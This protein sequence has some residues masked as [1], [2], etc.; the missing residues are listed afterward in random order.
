MGTENAIQVNPMKRTDAPRCAQ[1]EAPQHLEHAH[2]QVTGGGDEQERED[3]PGDELPVRRMLDLDRTP[4]ARVLRLAHEDGRGDGREER[5]PAPE[6]EDRVE[7]P[8]ARPAA[9]GVER[10]GHHRS[11][12]QPAELGARASSRTRGCGPSRCSGRRRAPGRPARP[13][14][15]RCLPGSGRRRTTSGWVVEMNSSCATPKKA[16]PARITGLRPMLSLRRP[17]SAEKAKL[18]M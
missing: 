4:R 7:G 2:G 18:P 12:H 3:G 9:E 16:M 1:P 13:R 10:P 14:P 6:Q 11:G 8:F 5:E 17:N 15:L